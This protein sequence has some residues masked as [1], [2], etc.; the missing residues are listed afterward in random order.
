MYKK[1]F[2]KEWS[3]G[4]MASYGWYLNCPTNNTPKSECGLREKFEDICLNKPISI[5]FNFRGGKRSQN[6]KS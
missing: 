5:D 4:H 6:A 3:S 1:D 2:L